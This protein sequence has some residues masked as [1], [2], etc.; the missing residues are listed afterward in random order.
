MTV[1]R[2]HVIGILINGTLDNS[3]FRNGTLG[4]GTLGNV[5]FGFG[6]INVPYEFPNG[7]LVN[8]TVV[9]DVGID[10]GFPMHHLNYGIFEPIDSS[11]SSNMRDTDARKAV[12]Y[13][14]MIRKINKM[15]EVNKHE[16]LA[17]EERENRLDLY[18]NDSSELKHVDTN[19][20]YRNSLIH[21]IGELR[22]LESRYYKRLCNCTHCKLLHWKDRW[23]MCRL[24]H[25]YLQTPQ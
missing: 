10:G 17:G 3:T 23:G 12:G 13:S 4:N 9:Q 5:T 20:V 6:Y 24:T 19:A 15:A 8:G 21:S 18:A 14:G 1:L 22:Q 11:I 7:T 16:P 25:A 2:G